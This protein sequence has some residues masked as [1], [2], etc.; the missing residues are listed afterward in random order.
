M[1]IEELTTMFCSASFGSGEYDCGDS[2]GADSTVFFS[3]KSSASGSLSVL[4]DSLFLKKIFSL[5]FYQVF[6]PLWLKLLAS[7][8]FSIFFCWI[9]K[10]EQGFEL[11][12]E[13]SEPCISNHFC[14][15][16]PKIKTSKT[17]QCW[18]FISISLIE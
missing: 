15:F 17:S 8:L 16:H 1:L 2:T 13:S 11:K 7:K 14:F 12:S 3:D 6:Y 10:I 4:S 9:A 5:F 18:R